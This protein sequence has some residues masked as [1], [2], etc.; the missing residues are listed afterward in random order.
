MSRIHAGRVDQWIGVLTV[1]NRGQSGLF[2][3][4]VT[5]SDEYLPRFDPPRGAPL[6]SV[7]G[8]M[9]R[10]LTALTIMLPIAA[11]RWAVEH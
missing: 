6:H 9:C 2:R 3:L 4:R 11:E 1:V 10:V 5:H 8:P 7:P